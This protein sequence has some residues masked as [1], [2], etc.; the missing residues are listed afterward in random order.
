MHVRR[1]THPRCMPYKHISQMHAL[2]FCLTHTQSCTCTHSQL[3]HT[4]ED[5]WT[6]TTTRA[7]GHIGT[8]PSNSLIPPQS[9]TTNSAQHS[10]HSTAPTQ[11]RPQC[12]IMTCA[13]C[14][15]SSL[16]WPN[17]ALSTGRV[18]FNT[19]FPASE[20]LAN[21]TTTNRIA[22]VQIE[23]HGVQ[24]ANPEQNQYSTSGTVTRART[25]PVTT[26][27][28]HTAPVPTQ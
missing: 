13:V 20:R 8:H 11:V 2:P 18:C 1:S 24:R 22:A 28:Q 16:D 6:H 21:P 12:V 5:T 17:P 14:A 4:Q 15:F 7:K 25:V 9:C 10:K 27:P 3:R 26:H 19:V 23:L